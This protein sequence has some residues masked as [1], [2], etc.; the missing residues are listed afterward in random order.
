MAAGVQAFNFYFLLRVSFLVDFLF[1]EPPPGVMGNPSDA[2]V[3]N[4][5]AR[6]GLPLAVSICEIAFI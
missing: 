6:T 2:E 1:L 4:V 3:E 5:L